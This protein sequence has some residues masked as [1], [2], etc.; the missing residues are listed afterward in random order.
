MWI[1]APKSTTAALRS[2]RNQLSSEGDGHFRTKAG[3]QGRPHATL[4]ELA[5]VPALATID[6]T[7]R[8]GGLIAGAYS[9]PGES[10]IE[11]TWLPRPRP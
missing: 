10:S 4:R 6:H 8:R 5:A 7:V 1:S 11:E 9:F 2:L 3:Y